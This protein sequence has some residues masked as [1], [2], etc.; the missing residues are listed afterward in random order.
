[1]KRARLD[2]SIILFLY[3]I[4]THTRKSNWT[5]VFHHP[6]IICVRRQL[7]FMFYQIIEKKNLYSRLYFSVASS[8]PTRRATSSRLFYVDY[9]NERTSQTH[10]LFLSHNE[11]SIFPHHC[12]TLV[13]FSF[14]YFQTLL[15]IFLL[16]PFW[17]LYEIREYIRIADPTS[18]I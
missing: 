3:N 16:A 5:A 15:F 7:N 12:N 11:N 9:N 1:M 17:H 6:S 13:K 2:W 10:P 18:K 4:H 14:K 8:R